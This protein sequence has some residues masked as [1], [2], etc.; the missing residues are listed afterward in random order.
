VHLQLYGKAGTKASAYTLRNYRQA[1][2]ALLRDWQEV[3]L[4]HPRR[5]DAALLLRRWES[6]GAAHSTV[7]VRLAGVRSLYA[8]LRWTECTNADPFKDVHPAA[9]HTPAHAK[10]QPYDDGSIERLLAV[11]QGDDRFLVLLGAH[12]GLRA[13][14]ILAIRWDHID[15]DAGML[16]VIHGK[17]GKRRRVTISRSLLAALTDQPEKSGFVIATYRTTETARARMKALCQKAGTRYLAI[18]S[19]RHACGTRIYRAT[20]K[21]E[22]AQHHLG[23]SDISTTAVYAKW[24]DDAVKNSVGNW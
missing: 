22:D 10:R 21:L 24:S 14:E 23:H 17:G 1:V 4:L 11:A 15:L 13:A 19:L 8:A 9:D 7:T 2:S 6:A 5:E 12:G 18:H 20:G 16:T 3:N